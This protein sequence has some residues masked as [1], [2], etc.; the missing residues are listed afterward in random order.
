MERVRDELSSAVHE[1]LGALAPAIAA[2]PGPGATPTVAA[3]RSCPPSA[4]ASYA[5]ALASGGRY[6]ALGQQLQAAYREIRRADE[7]GDALG[8]TP[9]YRLEVKRT[10]DLHQQLLTDYREM[11]V[12]FYD[13]LGAELRHAGCK[14][15]AHGLGQP[16]APAT[17]GG[18]AETADPANARAWELDEPAAE[19]A[20][21]EPD[22]P[23]ATAAAAAT[24]ASSAAAEP[25][26]A[27][28]IWIDIDNS[29]CTQPTRLAID[30]QPL[31]DIGAGKRTS[32]RTRSG[33]HEV[34]ALPAS[35]GRACGDPGTLR[36]AYLHEG[37]TLAIHCGR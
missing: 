31:G 17:G 28:A 14:V 33:P 16:A 6:L 36:K 19:A 22:A 32:V 35:D 25:A 30:G 3:A 26:A 9:D 10:K 24:P 13:Q 11:R 37:W 23:R 8:L 15:G 29:L 4:G 7:L 20:P 5:R 27:P 18:P 34:C 2:G 12:A 1:T 21:P